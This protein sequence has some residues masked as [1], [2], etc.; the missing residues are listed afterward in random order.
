MDGDV[1][2]ALKYTKA[3][4]PNVLRDNEHVYFRLRCRKF[5]EM[6][7]QSAEMQNPPKKSNGHNGDWY[8]DIINNDM[9]L[10]DHHQN[11]NWDRMDTEDASENQAAFLQETVVA[12]GRDL[13]AEFKDDPRREV[14]K[15]LEDAFA[16]IAYPD[17]LNSKEVAHYF[18]PNGRVAV[19][20]ELNAAILRKSSRISRDCLYLH[21]FEL[22]S[23]GKSS[24][25][26]LEKLIQQTTVLIEDLAEGGGPGAFV[27]IDDFVKPK[28][29]L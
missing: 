23:L 16:L 14:Q 13:R 26:A 24:S 28:N 4:Y 1:D 12:Y 11:S 15:A 17:P 27:N 21:R 8:D 10:D 5:I 22:E 7:R 6:I 29:G 19:A 9:D 25:A 20:E 2:R 3:F 18:D